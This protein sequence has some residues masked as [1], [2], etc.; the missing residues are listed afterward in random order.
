VPEGEFNFLGYSFGRMYSA[1]T[2]KTYLVS[3]AKC[4]DSSEHGSVMPMNRA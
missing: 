3:V 2:G 4:V 1:R